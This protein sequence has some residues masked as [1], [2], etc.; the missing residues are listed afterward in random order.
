MCPFRF[1]LTA[2]HRGDVP[3]ALATLIDGLDAAVAMAD[4][5]YDSDQIRR[6]VT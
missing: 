4:T 1:H 3:Q 6:A 2:G 5:A